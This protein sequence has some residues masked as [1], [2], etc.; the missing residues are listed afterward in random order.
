MRKRT[1]SSLHTVLYI[2][3]SNIEKKNGENIHTRN[4]NMNSKHNQN[5]IHDLKV[6]ERSLLQNYKQYNNE[7]LFHIISIL[8][9]FY[10]LFRLYM[11]LI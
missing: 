3:L 2:P 9:T 5:I 4:I 8:I 7:A 11:L 10:F 1:K 6:I